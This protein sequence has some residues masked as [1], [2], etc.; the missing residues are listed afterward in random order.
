MGARIAALRRDA[1][2]SQAELGKRLGVSASAVGMYEQGRREPRRI[3][4][5]PCPGSSASPPIT[6]SRVGPSPCRT[7]RPSPGSCGRAW[8]PPSRPSAPAGPSH[9]P[10]THWRLCS[11]PC[12]RMLDGNGILKYPVRE[13]KTEKCI[14]ASS[15]TVGREACSRREF[16]QRRN[17]HRPKDERQRNPCLAARGFFACGIKSRRGQAPRPTLTVLFMQFSIFH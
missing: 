12:S 1:G 9:L 7:R 14:A 5:W 2:W 3:P 8:N 15:G 10:G 11:P 16:R 17:S 4:W 13:L 6:Y